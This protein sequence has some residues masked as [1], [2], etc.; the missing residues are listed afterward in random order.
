M[1]SFKALVLEKHEK[2]VTATIKTLTV[3]DLPEGEVIVSVAY[4][5]LN[6][7]DGLA[8]TNSA[9]VVRTF[10]MVPGIDLAGTVE[11]STNANFKVG[12]PVVLT[13]WGVGERYWGGYTQ[14]ARLKAKWL[15]HL[16]TNLTLKQAMQI[17][18]AGF[19][20][21]LCVMALEDHQI[22]PDKGEVVV[23]GS[24]GG[25]GSL[26]IAILAK[27]GYT[28]VASTGRAESLKNYLTALG[29]SRIIGR[30]E[31]SKRP[32]EKE[33]WAG[34]VDTVGSETL[35]AL[36]RQTAY[37]G[38]VAACGLAGGGDLPTS[39]YP[40]ILRGISLLGIDS[41]M[42]PAD[43]RQI[44]WNRLANILDDSVFDLVSEGTTT[45]EDVPELGSKIIN[46]QVK[47]RVVVELGS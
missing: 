20:A 29:A 4:S 14:K 31:A 13:G 12:D 17:G 21:M 33:L 7:K 5:S 46:G 39:V 43:R 42:C 16:P 47:G 8:I 44:A 18:T 40:F 34:A 45:L 38:A 41:V 2:E 11:E 22:T 30:F 37:G 3:D 32:L 6:Y 1:D 19:T 15:T 27:L 35:A 9:P 23:T 25:V 26:T 10:P 28:V 24:A 36:L